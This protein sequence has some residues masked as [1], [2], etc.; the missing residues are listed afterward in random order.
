MGGDCGDKKDCEGYRRQ[1]TL[2][3]QKKER[4]KSLQDSVQPSEGTFLGTDSPFYSIL[5]DGEE[6]LRTWI[7]VFRVV[8]SVAI[9]KFSFVRVY[10]TDGG[11]PLVIRGDYVERGEVIIPKNGRER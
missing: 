4:L 6:D 9:D 3:S 10:E 7:T 2:L 1:S 5:E 11:I 8:N